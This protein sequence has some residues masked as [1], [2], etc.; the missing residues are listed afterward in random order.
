MTFSFNAFIVSDVSFG[1]LLEA[2]KTRQKAKYVKKETWPACKYVV[3][4][5]LWLQAIFR[6]FAFCR[7]SST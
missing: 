3:R 4:E 1:L 6:E 2:R 7:A 5:N